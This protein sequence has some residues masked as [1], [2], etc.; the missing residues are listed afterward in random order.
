MTRNRPDAS[1]DEATGGDTEA[2]FARPLVPRTERLFVTLLTAVALAVSTVAI[3]SEMAGYAF[4][5]QLQSDS[6]SLPAWRM[7]LIGH[8][9]SVTG[10]RFSSVPYFVPDMPL[11]LLAQALAGATGPALILHSVLVFWLFQAVLTWIAFQINGD[12]LKSAALIALAASV[13]AV[14]SQLT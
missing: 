6:L 11:Y 9:Y 8:A 2:P 4:H 7:D 1:G 13:L 12:W 14:L 3:V 10:W 5:G